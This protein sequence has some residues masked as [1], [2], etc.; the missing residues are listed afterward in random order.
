MI[1]PRPIFSILLTTCNQLNS[2]KFTLLALKDQA[3]AVEHEILVV[4]CGSDD[5]S[6]Q[7]L[8]ARVERLERALTDM[9]PQ[10]Q[11]ALKKLNARLDKLERAV[12]ER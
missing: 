2:L 5:G 8:A 6:A 1:A 7:F 10:L 11:Q 9:V 3:P 12:Q 4:D